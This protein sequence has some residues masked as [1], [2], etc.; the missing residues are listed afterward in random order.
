[1]L[2]LCYKILKRFEI[3][4]EQGDEIHEKPFNWVV[5]GF[6]SLKCV[7]FLLKTDK[8]M[9]KTRK[10]CFISIFLKNNFNN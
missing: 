4:T 5:R 7:Y 6:F 10:V 1:M 3:E 2:R 9:P 8:K